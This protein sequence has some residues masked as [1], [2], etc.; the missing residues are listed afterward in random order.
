MEMENSLLQ[1]DR[2]MKESLRIISS[3]ESEEGFLKSYDILESN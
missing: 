3:W 1:M 2:F